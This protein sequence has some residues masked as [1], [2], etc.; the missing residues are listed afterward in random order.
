MTLV[1]LHDQC[2]GRGRA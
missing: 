1:L 2:V